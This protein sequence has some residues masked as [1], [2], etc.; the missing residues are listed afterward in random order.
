V[1]LTEP[2]S[3]WNPAAG[4]WPSPA[5]YRDPDAPDR[6][7][8]A[9]AVSEALQGHGI[10]TRL[11]ERLADTARGQGI[12]TFEAYVLSENRRMLDVFRD[13]GFVAT[14]ELEGGVCHVVLS[15]SATGVFA[16]RAAARSRQ[17]ATASMKT[18][19]EPRVVAIVGANRERGKIGS[20]VLH[21]LLA[22]GFTGSIV[23]V[24][25]TATTIEGLPTYPRVADIPGAVDLAVIV[26]PAVHVLAAVDDCIGK[27]VR[28]ICVISAGFSESDAEG[29]A[30]EVL[31]VERIRRAGCRLIGPNCM[32]LDQYR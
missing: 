22:G 2:R 14:T 11:L 5:F 32:G 13:S 3:S 30:R 4:S 19:F 23:P 27:G 25:P 15:L 8:V 12:D 6:A 17:A 31:L 9:F 28:A 21:N 1:A 10:G 16:D 20:E 18:F 24:H 26:V 29:R 7:E